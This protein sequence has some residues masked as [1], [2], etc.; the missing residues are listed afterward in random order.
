M[1]REC[2]AEKGEFLS[3]GRAEEALRQSQ[4]RSQSRQVHQLKKCFFRSALWIF[5][6]ARESGL[7]CL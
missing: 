4:W 2:S 7:S 3:M 1:K 5:S 6:R